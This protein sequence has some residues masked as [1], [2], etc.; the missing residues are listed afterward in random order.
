MKLAIPELSLV[1]LVGPSGSGKSTFAHRHFAPTQVLSSDVFRAMVADDENDQ[2]ATAEA[3]D[4]LYHVAGKRLRAGRLTVVDATH[5]QRE[6]RAKVVALAREHDVLPVAIVFDLPRSVCATRNENHRAL[7]DHVLRRQRDALRRSLRHLHKEGFRKVHVLST[8]DEV[9]SVELQYEKAYNDKRELTGP[10]DVIGDVH[11]CRAELENLLGRLGYRLDRDDSGRPVGAAHP[12]GRTAVFVG[13]LVD[14]GPDTPGVLRLVMGMVAAGT[15]LCVAGNHEN[16]LVRAL[17]GRKVTVSHGLAESLA[18]LSG[19]SPD[20]RASA[21]D[22]MYSLVSHYRLDGG[23]LVVAHAGLKEDYHGRASARVRSF[24]LYGETTGETDEYG[25]PVRHPWAR[26][27]RGAAAVVYGHTPVLEPTWLNNTICLDT[28]CVFGGSLTALRWPERDLVSVPAEQVHYQPVRPLAVEAGRSDDSQE[29]PDDL[30]RIQDVLGTR[31]LE[32]RLL[33]RLKVLEENAAGALEV[34]SRFAIDPRWLVY[35]PPTMAPSATTEEEGLLEHPAEAFQYYRAERVS[36][37]LCE[38]KH[39]GSRAVVVLCRDGEVARRRFGIADGTTGAVHTRTGRA[40]FNDQERTER[41]LARLRG[42]VD[43][44]GLWAELGT[45]WLVLDAELLPWSAKAGDLLR[46]YASVGA[47]ARAALPTA[48][49]VLEKVAGRGIDV[50][51]LLGRQRR[52]LS[53]VDAFTAAYGGYCWPVDDL[54]GVV[55]APFQILAGEGACYADQ[56]HLWHLER[57]DRLVAADPELLRTTRRFLVNVDDPESAAAGVAWWTELTER[58]GEGMVVKPLSGVAQ[59]ALQPG[60]KCRGRE[61]LRI[62]YGPDYTEPANLAR[63]RQRNLGRK[64]S[65]A[66]REHAL[67]WEAL[68]RFVEG[69]PLWRVHEVVFAVLALESEP[70]DPRL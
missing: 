11:G 35:L 64:R 36:Q 29:R 61:Y 13:D 58:G 14:R 50:G 31:T 23:D 66:L 19:E 2:S 40:F 57:I 70:I 17:D 53:H 34:M 5:V 33:G 55:L 20:F 46:Q 12:D 65:L 38:E 47:A 27:Y 49:S 59:G 26:E 25:L 3:F 62:I 37:V 7:P 45:D 28:G 9:E 69:E 15:A 6:D 60:I 54:K 8:V 16:K 63:L 67:G 30:L 68:H 18:Q 43:E 32:T 24:C 4:A 44:A 1:A 51:E 39:M 10:F 21:R 48:V 52:R 41:L 42:A 22:F 56:D